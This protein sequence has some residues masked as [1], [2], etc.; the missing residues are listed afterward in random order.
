MKNLDQ[1][2]ACMKDELDRFLGP[3]SG[4][5]PG[6]YV[7]SGCEGVNVMKYSSL[8][9]PANT[10]FMSVANVSLVMCNHQSLPSSHSHILKG[11]I[12]LNSHTG[13]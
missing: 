3:P 2:E 8:M 4:Y 1:W 12:H 10:P 11:D 9:D 13:T 6:C 7:N 5:I